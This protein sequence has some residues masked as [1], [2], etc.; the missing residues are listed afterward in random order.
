MVYLKLEDNTGYMI[1]RREGR[2]DK[3]NELYW[4]NIKVIK[5]LGRKTDAG[6]W[7]DG[8]S[9]KSTCCLCNGL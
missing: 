9:F 2:Q 4:L 7:R 8:S 3:D 5:P 1:S 6:G